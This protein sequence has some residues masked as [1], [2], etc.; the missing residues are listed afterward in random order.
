MLFFFFFDR[1][2][3]FTKFLNLEI[4]SFIFNYICLPAITNWAS[5]NKKKMYFYMFKLLFPEYLTAAAETF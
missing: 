5:F 4:I 1:I 3:I 2:F